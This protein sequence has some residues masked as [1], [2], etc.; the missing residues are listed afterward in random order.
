MGYE[1]TGEDE[2]GHAVFTL[3]CR[4]GAKDFRLTNELA[5]EMGWRV[6][7]KLHLCNDCVKAR[8]IRK[9]LDPKER[10]WQ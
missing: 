1:K 9:G 7:G 4:C 6:S 2:D 5:Y 8:R 10:A 3:T